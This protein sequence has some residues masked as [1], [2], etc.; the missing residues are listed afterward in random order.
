MINY[1]VPGPGQRAAAGSVIIE[2]TAAGSGLIAASPYIPG[3]LSL[4]LGSLSQATLVLWLKILEGL[5]NPASINPTL[6]YLGQVIHIAVS[7]YILLIFIRILLT[8]VNP[9][10]YSPVMRFLSKATDPVLNRARR[11]LPL[12]LGGLDFSPIVAIMII[13]LAGATLG[14]WLI[15]V[16]QGLPPSVALPILALELIGFLDSLAR[17]LMAL[18]GIRFIIAL[19]QPSPYNILVRIIYGLTEPLL[20]PLRRFFPPL[21]RGLDLRPLIFLL[22][23]LLI[24]MA[25]LYPLARGAAAWMSDLFGA[26]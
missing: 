23:V 15:R 3:Q 14:Q 9:N 21:G 1:L 18:M 2:P 17:M 4:C 20:S 11:L 7:L 13:Y 8:W 12:T 24:Q 10:P 19:V 6:V 25:V 5:L 16:G 22:I 26:G